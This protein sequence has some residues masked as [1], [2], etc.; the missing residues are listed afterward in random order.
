[1]R[2][3]HARLMVVMLVATVTVVWPGSSPAQVVDACT[4]EATISP[5]GLGKIVH[6]GA[7][8]SCNNPH[9]SISVVGCLLLDGAPVYCLP[10]TQTNSA[11]ASVDLAFPCVPGVWA[12]VAVGFGADR[13]LP[14]LDPSPLVVA[15]ECRPLAPEPE[16]TSAP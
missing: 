3:R 1:M 5:P 11:S 8:Y 16:S 10:D 2:T 7:S 13:A 12:V 14:A 4:A 9:L 6:G 15:T